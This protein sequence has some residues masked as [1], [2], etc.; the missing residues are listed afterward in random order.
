MVISQTTLLLALRDIYRDVCLR[1]GKVERKV[2]KLCTA[3]LGP[4]ECRNILE[5]ARLERQNRNGGAT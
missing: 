3:V 5:A 1:D 2:K 4:A